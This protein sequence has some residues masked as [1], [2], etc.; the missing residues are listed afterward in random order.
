[1]AHDFSNN[2][3]GDAVDGGGFQ[4]TQPAS[5]TSGGTQP[6]LR[7][8][9]SP[10]FLFIHHPNRWQI[11]N[12]EL[13]PVLAEL[14]QSVGQNFVGPR[15]NGEMSPAIAKFI[16]DGWTVIPHDVIPGG[17]VRKYDGANG[18]V[19]LTKWQ[20]PRQHGLRALEPKTDTSGYVAFLKDLVDRQV[21][22][23]PPEY[24]VEQLVA[25]ARAAMERAA[26]Y[27]ATEAGKAEYEKLK[28][29]LE[30]VEVATGFRVETE[31]VKP[32]TKRTR[33]KATVKTENADG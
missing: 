25:N 11:I 29:N 4:A 16:E 10:N 23:R 5:L 20:T 26:P 8:A 22:N 2:T 19:H 7:M 33:K 3:T 24:V 15:A 31:V 27:T 21:I 13:L 32:K 1:M 18:A 28:T 6:K 9:P 30:A 14:R 17:Y 12:G